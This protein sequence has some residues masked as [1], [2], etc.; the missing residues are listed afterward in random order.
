MPDLSDLPPGV[1]LDTDHGLDCARVATDACTALVYR[2]GAH[3]AAWQ[4]AGHE[5]VL[6]RSDHA[7]YADGQPIRGGVPVCFPWFG[8]K[9]DDPDAPAHG[10]VRT[11][12]WAW[13]TLAAHDDNVRLALASSGGP[14][15]VTLDVRLGPAL[16]LTLTAFAF[17]TA[18]GPATFEAALHTYLAVADARDVTLHGLEKARYLDKMID[19]TPTVE[20]DGQPLQFTGE[21]DRVYLDVDRPTTLTDPG[22]ARRITLDHDAPS[23][24]VWNPWTDKAARMTDFGDDEWPGM[25]CIE[26]GAIG[27][28]AVTL[29]PGEQASLSV[30]LSVEL[31]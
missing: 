27:P 5:P 9:A 18:D 19:G 30:T 25:C 14:F 13:H 8:P 24:V 15:D 2:H 7:T 20:P 4:P 29:E 17:P 12:A 26:T 1:T 28:N 3:V 31:L 6:W 21:T 23:V 22:L 16:T 11:K 10:L